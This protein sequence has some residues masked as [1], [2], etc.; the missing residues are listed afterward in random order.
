MTP[1]HQS[2]FLVLGGGVSG[3][4]AA[5]RLSRA[6][7]RVTV[8]EAEEEPGG[9][10][11]TLQ[12]AGHRFDIGGHR[13]FTRDTEVDA[14]VRELGGEELLEVA[15][16]SRILLDGR[17]LPMPPRILSTMR[18]VPTVGLATAAH[19][20]GRLPPR[21]GP[22]P[23]PTDLEDYLL[24]RFGRALY[25]LIFEGYTAKVWGLHP[26]EMSADW[27]AARIE[28]L[29]LASLARRA[30][31]FRGRGPRDAG[32]FLYPRLG[33][34]HIA[35]RMAEAVQEAG[36]EIVTGARVESAGRVEAGG[37]ELRAGER[38]WRGGQL[39]STAPIADLAEL[40]RPALED[41]ALA[42]ARALRYRSVVL[43]VLRVR[44]EQ[45]VSP[46]TWL[47]FPDPGTPFCRMHEPP[48]WSPALSPPGERSLVLEYFCARGDALWRQPDEQLAEGA[49]ARLDQLGLLPRG[50]VVDHLVLRFPRAYPVYDLDYLRP[51]QRVQ[52]ALSRLPGL[53]TA[54]RAGS[55]LY[56][57][58]DESVRQGLDAARALLVG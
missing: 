13:F 24:R 20:L 51:L 38:R 36:G 57:A 55:F 41:D 58:S 39:L 10:C 17:F 54:G 21:R 37:W 46:D 30:V 56:L 23:P 31:G 28:G 12:W 47:Y 35:R 49:V 7:R 6:G 48:N 43:V 4:A 53:H 14:L 32:S 26:R 15:R 2:E 8:L 50:R 16:V 3:L 27:G 29:S 45:P 9:L 34:G 52:G 11:R 42:A 19:A 25:E 22:E 5:L 44:G 40:L 1:A 33:Y 18:V